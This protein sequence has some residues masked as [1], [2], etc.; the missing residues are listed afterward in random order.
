[1]PS[2]ET[3]LLQYSMSLYK[4]YSIGIGTCQTRGQPYNDTVPDEVSEYYW[5]LKYYAR[6]LLTSNNQT[7]TQPHFSKHIC[8][9]TQQFVNICG[10]SVNDQVISVEWTTA[11]FDLPPEG[12]A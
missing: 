4:S 6:V 9:I 2:Y 10:L 5:S 1:M 7:I 12:S 11:P 8:Q 3:A